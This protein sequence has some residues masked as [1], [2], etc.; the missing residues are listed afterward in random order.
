MKKTRKTTLSYEDISLEEQ[1]VILI[2][3]EA[4]KPTLSDMETLRQNLIKLIKYND[5]NYSDI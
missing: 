3:L 1:S 2:A 4:Y 5:G